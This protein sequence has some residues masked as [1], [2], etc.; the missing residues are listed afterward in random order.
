MTVRGSIK[1]DAPFGQEAT[2]T[3]TMTLGE[4]NE[5]KDAIQGADTEHYH[6]ASKMSRVIHRLV[7]R[8]N[9]EYHH[10]EEVEG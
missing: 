3:L 8:A 9:E 4:W 10:S 6:P 7:I 1:L 5:V 2:M